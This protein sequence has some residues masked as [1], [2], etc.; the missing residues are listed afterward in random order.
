MLTNLISF[1]T[2][3]AQTL[4]RDIKYDGTKNYKYY[5]NK[6]INTVFYFQN[7][8]EETVRKT[9]QNLPSKHSCGLDGISSKFIKIIEPAII[10]P[11]TLLINQVL[12]TGIFTD[13]LKIAK[14][15]PLFKKDDPKLL[16]NYRPISLLPT[17][18]KVIEKIIF[19]QLSTYFNENKL[20]FDN[21]CCAQPGQTGLF[22][23]SCCDLVVPW[24]HTG[25]SFQVLLPAGGIM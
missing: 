18:S 19:T 2:N 6:H 9:I 16:K 5:L 10:K 3:I 4:A 20:I 22:T 24:P 8:D 14:V 25:V 15:I 11:L 21:Q 12:N 17:I 1:F 23:Q 7:I 13:E